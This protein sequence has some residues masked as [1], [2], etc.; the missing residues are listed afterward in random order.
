[1]IWKM[2]MHSNRYPN[3][4]WWTEIQIETYGLRNVY[5]FK[6]VCESRLADRNKNRQMWFEN[7]YAFK[8]VSESKLVDRNK[9]MD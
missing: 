7:I 1:M 5:A 4:G 2:Y 3:P 8:Q 9:D 6:Q